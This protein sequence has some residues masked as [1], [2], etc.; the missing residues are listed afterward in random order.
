MSRRRSRGLRL[1]WRLFWGIVGGLLTFVVLSVSGLDLEM[2]IALAISG[3][4]AVAVAVVGPALL[5][6][7]ASV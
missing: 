7:L 2:P 1:G 5:E 4:A 6:V 3:G